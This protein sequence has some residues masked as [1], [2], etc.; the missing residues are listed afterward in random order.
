MGS[1]WQCYYSPSTWKTIN[2]DY[3]QLGIYYNEPRVVLQS[4]VP[5]IISRLPNKFM[6]LWA[7]LGNASCVKDCN[8]LQIYMRWVQSSFEGEM[9]NPTY[10]LEGRVRLE[11]GESRALGLLDQVRTTHGFWTRLTRKASTLSHNNS[12]N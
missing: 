10:D 8:F 12:T 9:T 4:K 5:F 7:V 3:E 1:I 2:Y 11:I 6:P